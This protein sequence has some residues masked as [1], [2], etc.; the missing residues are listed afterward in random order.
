VAETAKTFQCTVIT[1]Q[2]K[3][4][5]CRASSVIIPSHDGQLGILPGHMPIFCQLGLGAMEMKC[6]SAEDGQPSVECMLLIDGGF[7]M[8]NSNNLAVT[9]SSGFNMRDMTTEKLEQVIEDCKASIASPA[10]TAGQ[11][12]RQERRL[13][14]LESLRQHLPA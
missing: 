9:A 3:L 12:P 6:P 14:I 10:T 7:A 2:G 8:F 13:S 1:P 4:L 11:R 5:D